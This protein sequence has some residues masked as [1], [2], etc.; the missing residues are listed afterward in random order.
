MSRAQSR[1]IRKAYQRIARAYLGDADQQG[2][3]VGCELLAWY[4]NRHDRRA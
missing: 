4:L 1:R 3:A 2:L